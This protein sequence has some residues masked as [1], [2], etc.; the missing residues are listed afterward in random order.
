MHMRLFVLAVALFAT[1][2]LAQEPKIKVGDR[3]KMTCEE[4]PTLNKDYTVTAQ[5]VILVDFIGA[6]HVEG[7]TEAEAAR[8]VSAR[9]VDERILRRATVTVR[10]VSSNVAPVTYRG[11]V[12]STG[13]EPHRAGLRLA[14]VVK[15]ARPRE[16]TDLARIEVRG[17]D[18]STKLVDFTRYDPETNANNPLLQPG[19]TV[20]FYVKTAPGLVVLLGGVERPGGVTWER[21]MTVR[22]AIAKAG[23][24]TALAVETS[25][26]LERPGRNAVTLDLSD[27]SVDVPV[28]EGDRILVAMREN[29][30][31][32]T[33][34][35]AV[36]KGGFIEHKAGMTLTQAIEAGGGLRADADPERIRVT[37]SGQAQAVAFRYSELKS[38]RATDPVL[39]PGDK[40]MVDAKSMRRTDVL[41]S[42]TMLALLYILIGR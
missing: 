34:S 29:R 11:A 41:K 39:N 30:A 40:V 8:I 22:S 25:V 31:Y 19:D 9:L 17:R 27:P 6:V 1:T 16:D 10:I 21:G 2:A 26:R 5:G 28:Q 24:L 13:Q 4:E 23:G 33:V 18:G 36:N 32:V 35:G 20:T 42:L 14:D 3:L 7:N 15:K 12:Q 37:R 38:G